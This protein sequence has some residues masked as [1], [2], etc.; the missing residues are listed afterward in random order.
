MKAS[1]SESEYFK[2]MLRFT[3]FKA[4]KNFFKLFN[5]IIIWF[6]ILYKTFWKGFSNRGEL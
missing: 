1:W 6:L 5:Y 3:G 4:L 2:E